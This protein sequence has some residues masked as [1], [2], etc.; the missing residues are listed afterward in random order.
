M[1][2]RSGSFIVYPFLSAPL[3]C[4]F[5]FLGCCFS[6]CCF[7]CSFLFVGVVIIVVFS[8][9][10]FAVSLGFL[11][12]LLSFSCFSVGGRQVFVKNRTWSELWLPAIGRQK[13]NLRFWGV[14]FQ[15]VIFKTDAV[16]TENINIK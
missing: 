7:G 5:L 15:E 2:H 1:S 8:F 10:F 14:W 16:L 3:S 4:F 6:I 9:F 13:T 12:F 11:F